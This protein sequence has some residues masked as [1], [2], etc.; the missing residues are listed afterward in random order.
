MGSIT[1]LVD[2]GRCV[3]V[4]VVEVVERA[5]DVVCVNLARSPKLVF[6]LLE[7]KEGAAVLVN[8]G[9]GK[10][11]LVVDLGSYGT[12][13]ASRPFDLRLVVFSSLFEEASI[14]IF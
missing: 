13:M 9:N 10:M 5:V 3:V 14:R 8:K 2:V 4:L 12:V 6:N 7:S 11:S 1:F